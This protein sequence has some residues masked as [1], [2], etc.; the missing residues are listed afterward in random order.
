M[1]FDDNVPET[2]EKKGNKKIE[3]L[4]YKDGMLNVKTKI[5]GFDVARIYKDMEQKIFLIFH[6]KG[7]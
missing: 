3:F 4:L 5:N 1:E 7:F 6:E 2:K